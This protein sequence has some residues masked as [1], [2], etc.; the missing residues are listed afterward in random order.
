MEQR[1]SFHPPKR[2]VEIAVDSFWL[3]VLTA[4]AFYVF[5]LILGIVRPGEVVAMTVTFLVLCAAWG[6]HA[7]WAHRNEAYRARDPRL[8]EDRERRGF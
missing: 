5:G 7:W 2:G 1:E 4:M 6:G 8:H 3:A